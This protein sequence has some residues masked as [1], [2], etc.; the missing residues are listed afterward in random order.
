MPRL[1]NRNPAYRRHT[2]GRAVV[3]LK[4]QDVYLGSHAPPAAVRGFPLVGDSA[5]PS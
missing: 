5:V 4:G 1:T 3:T 2:S